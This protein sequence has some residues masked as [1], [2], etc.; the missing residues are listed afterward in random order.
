MLANNP[1]VEFS[2]RASSN[3]LGNQD[4]TMVMLDVRLPASNIALARTS[5][6]TALYTHWQHSDARAVVIE[7]ETVYYIHFDNRQAGFGR[8]VGLKP[9][10]LL[11]QGWELPLPS[12]LQHQ[13]HQSFTHTRMK[14]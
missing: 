12:H 1:L 3:Y 14:R 2:T 8:W 6:D 5:Y 9:V 10:K 7:S 4:D 11:R 13:A